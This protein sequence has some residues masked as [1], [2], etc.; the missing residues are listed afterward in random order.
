MA[1][2][3]ISLLREN[4]ESA[5][6]TLVNQLDPVPNPEAVLAALAE[7]GKASA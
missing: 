1:A 5:L 3:A 4:A 2:Q 6:K 7:M